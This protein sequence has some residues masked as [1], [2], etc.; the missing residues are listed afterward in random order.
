MFADNDSD[1]G[2]GTTAVLLGAT[3]PAFGSKPYP[4]QVLSFATA[5]PPDHC[6]LGEFIFSSS[7]AVVSLTG[8]FFQWMAEEFCGSNGF[9]LGAQRASNTGSS[10]SEDRS[11]LW[12]SRESSVYRRNSADLAKLTEAIEST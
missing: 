2:S 1:F 4:A 9:L 7:S 10:G 8:T 6:G 11:F 5:N 12:V 3:A